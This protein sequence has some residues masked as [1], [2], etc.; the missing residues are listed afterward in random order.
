M[1]IYWKFGLYHKM[2]NK[3][4]I[5]NL[6]IFI[7]LTSAAR[8]FAQSTVDYNDLIEGGEPALY[9]Y[10]DSKMITYPENS[11]SRGTFGLSVAE[12]VLGSKGKILEVNIINSL[13]P[14]IDTQVKELLNNTQDLWKKTEY[15]TTRLYFQFRYR[16]IT[17]SYKQANYQFIDN[18]KFLLPVFITAVEF[19]NDKLQIMPDDSLVM[20]ATLAGRQNNYQLAAHYLDE[21]IQRH[22][23]STQLYQKRI[24]VNTKLNNQNGVAEDLKKLS[25]FADGIPVNQLIVE[26]YK[27]MLPKDST[28][29]IPQNYLRGK[30]FPEFPGEEK[31]L[32]DYLNQN[33]VY[34][35]QAKKAGIQ[36]NVNVNFVI[37]EEGFVRDVNVSQ[38]IGGGCDEEAIRLIQDM[39]RWKPGIDILGE[40]VKCTMHLL[41]KFY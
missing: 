16:I 25:G 5:L 30:Y 37:D 27:E 33:L 11:A 22:P 38:G 6:L 21:I 4:M 12:L 14:D 39:P 20:K 7:M 36:G 19:G 34:P 13:D 15:D 40:P 2:T 9:N 26:D 1:R 28:G 32:F 3:K 24:S 8:S 41:V 31:G 17:D 35:K 23:Y 10:L 18:E 29:N